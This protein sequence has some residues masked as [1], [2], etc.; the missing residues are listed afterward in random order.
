MPG[1]CGPLTLGCLSFVL[2]IMQ[3]CL[4]TQDLYPQMLTA[5]A[6]LYASVQVL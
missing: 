6:P 3:L 2:F 1:L 5:Y 4:I